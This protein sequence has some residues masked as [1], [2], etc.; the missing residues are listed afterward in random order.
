[1][2]QTTKPTTYDIDMVQMYHSLTTFTKI[3]V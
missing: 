2:N 3:R 1:L